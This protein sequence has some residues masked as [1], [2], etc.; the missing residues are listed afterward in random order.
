MESN[1]HVMEKVLEEKRDGVDGKPLKNPKIMER[2][3]HVMEKV[4]EE[5][6]LCHRHQYWADKK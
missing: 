2:N 4:L 6:R 5:K 1:T 3:R